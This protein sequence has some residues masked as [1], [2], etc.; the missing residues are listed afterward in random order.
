MAN[1][2]MFQKVENPCITMR[3]TTLKSLFK[4]VY[5]FFLHYSSCVNHDFPTHFFLIFHHTSHTHS[6]SVILPFFH[7][8]TAPITTTI[9]IFNNKER[10]II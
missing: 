8:S 10:I 6:S 9:K 3:K 4:T 2:M 5:N 7:Y 1:H